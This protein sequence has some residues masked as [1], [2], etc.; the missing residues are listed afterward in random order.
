MS[1]TKDRLYCE[2]KYPDDFAQ[3]STCILEELE[4]EE[5]EDDESF[6]PKSK[7]GGDFCYEKYKWFDEYEELNSCL[8]DQGFPKDSTYC[9]SEET[10]KIFQID[11]SL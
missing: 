4:Y 2:L 7:L 10:F 5:A 8:E 6:D 9:N 1:V 3:M 11:D